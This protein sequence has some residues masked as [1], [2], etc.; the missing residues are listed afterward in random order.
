MPTLFTCPHCGTQSSAADHLA[1]QSG[2]CGSCGKPITIPPHP[3]WQAVDRRGVDYRQ[4][5]PPSRPWWP[6]A[7]AVGLPCALI[8]LCCGGPLLVTIVSGPIDPAEEF[9]PVD[10]EV[11]PGPEQP[12]PRPAA[13]PPKPKASAQVVT[14][15][16]YDRLDN[17][18]SYRQAVAVIGAEG[19]ELARNR[20]EGAPGVM[21]SVETVMYAWT[22]AD[23]SNMNAM[24][25]NDK[26]MQKAQFG[27]K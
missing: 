16:K 25:Q 7:L 14:R 23:G 27:L 1:G 12:G 17:G 4:V 15:A 13:T 26:L 3:D 2:P 11:A 21:E 8:A 18:M 9:S 20:V 22:N 19:E 5:T 10:D 6:I 24:F